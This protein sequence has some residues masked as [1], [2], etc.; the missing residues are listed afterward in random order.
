MVKYEPQVGSS[1]TPAKMVGSQYTVNVDDV[2]WLS[3]TGLKALSSW[4]RS[5]DL[6]TVI[7]E[8]IKHSK[9]RKLTDEVWLAA[10]LEGTDHPYHKCKQEEPWLTEMQL[11]ENEDGPLYWCPGCGY[12]ADNGVAMAIRLNEVSI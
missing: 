9:L 7:H 4:K 1:T 8:N 2:A 11:R 3:L 12:V 6:T 10:L 5:C